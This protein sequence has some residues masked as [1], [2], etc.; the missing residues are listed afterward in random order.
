MSSLPVLVLC[1]DYWHPARTARTGLAP[2]AAEGFAFDWIE[3][4]REWS[5]ERMAEYP[6][7]LLTK[8]NNVSQVD[9]RPWVTKDVEL[10]FHEYIRNGGGLLVIHS[11]STGY[12]ELPTLRALLGGV[13]ASHPPQCPVAVEPVR[14]HPVT[15][16]VTPFTVFDEHYFMSLD[17]TAAHVILT[18][19]SEYGVQPGG[20]TRSE[21]DG[22]VC[23]LTPGHNLDVWLHP[24]YQTLIRN[25]LRWCGRVGEP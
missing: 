3:D 20:W 12:G 23:L 18:T 8:S 16:G 19:T 14:S 17:D 5:A 11:G 7:V 6:A 15:S 9:N 24:C 13:F 25:G 10:A 22:R 1:D 4:A 21:G 2:L